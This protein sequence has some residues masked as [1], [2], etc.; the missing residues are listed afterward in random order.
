MGLVGE[1]KQLMQEKHLDLVLGI[2]K[3]FATIIV[4]L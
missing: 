4:L 2:H 1:F 3:V